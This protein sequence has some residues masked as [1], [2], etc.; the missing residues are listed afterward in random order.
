VFVTNRSPASLLVG[1]SRPAI[2]DV[3]SHD[4]PAFT[5]SVPLSLGPTRVVVGDILNADG[6]R[7]RRAFAVS[8]D[9][10]RITIYD[11]VR[12][13]IE[14]EVTTGRGPQAFVVD[15]ENGLGYVA[16]FTDSY[17]GVVDLDQRR[18]NTYGTIVA[19]FGKPEP[20]RAAK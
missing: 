20:P 8:F 18:P 13:R 10:R 17:I 11:P 15:E 19:S 5:D 12:G 4:L 3:A 16:H 6:E 14:A 7:E 1:Q 2:A 9:S